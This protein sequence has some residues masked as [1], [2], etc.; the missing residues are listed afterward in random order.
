LAALDG[1]KSLAGV[2]SVN[3]LSWEK[4][5]KGLPGNHSVHI[6]AVV[7]CSPHNKK[8]KEWSED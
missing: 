2:K 7:D 5:N 3:T 4:G 6:P 1:S 8:V